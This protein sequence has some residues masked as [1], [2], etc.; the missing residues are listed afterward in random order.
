MTMALPTSSTRPFGTMLTAMVTPFSPDGAVDLDAAVA[1][2]R[3]LVDGGHD[4]LVLNGTTG[5]SPTTHAPEK[6]DLVRAVVDAVG[7]RAVVVAGAGSNDTDH[8]IRMAEQSAAAGAHGL[9]VVSPYYSR[10]SQEGIVQHTTAIADST[11]LPVMVYDIPGRSGVRLTSETYERLAGN[12]KIVAVKDATGDVYAAAQNIARTGLAWYSGD[13]ALYLPF[14]AHG[15][16]GLVSVVGHVVGRE[17]VEIGQAFQ[18]GDHARATSLFVSIVPVIDA[19]MGGGFGVVM[20]KSAL[21]D[22]GLIPD[23]HLRLPQVGATQAEAE[24]VRTALRAVGL[25]DGS[26]SL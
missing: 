9:L 1:L 3:H 14:L 21:V 24:A 4:G 16:V 26:A 17:L 20:I 23:G 13:D 19:V 25:L 6:A 11:D 2:A 15:A 8:S 10:P 12:D 18:A 5:A 7:D 22:L